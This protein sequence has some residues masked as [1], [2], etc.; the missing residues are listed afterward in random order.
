MFTGIIEETGSIRE[1]NRLERT[2]ELKIEAAHVMKE[3]QLGDSMAINGTCLT[4]TDYTDWSFSVVV[5]Q[6][7][8]QS[9]SLSKL[10]EL[11]IVNLERWM[12]AEVRF[13]DHFVT[14]HVY[15][16]GRIIQKTMND[17]EK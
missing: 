7:T 2:L 4:V 16:T 12:Y 17:N 8:F 9:I 3:I 11:S 10:A 6:E 5:M 1:I 15:G 13:G 14:V